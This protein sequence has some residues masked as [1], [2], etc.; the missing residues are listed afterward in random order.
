MSELFNGAQAVIMKE[1]PEAIYVQSIGRTT[2]LCQGDGGDHASFICS[3]RKD[4]A[5]GHLLKPL[6]HIVPS[7]SLSHSI[8]NLS[9]SLHSNDSD[10]SYGENISTAILNI[11]K[12][13]EEVMLVRVICLIITTT[14]QYFLE[15]TYLFHA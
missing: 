1:T 3:T 10:L 6:F 4:S 11:K 15:Q 9:K 14:W 5:I 7:S 13:A 2:W 12:N 8:I